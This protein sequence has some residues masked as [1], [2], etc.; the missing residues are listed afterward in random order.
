MTISNF[1]VKNQ[2]LLEGKN[3]KLLQ[4]YDSLVALKYNGDLYLGKDHDYSK[5]TSK[6]VT[7][8]TGLTT[9]ERRQ[10]LKNGTIKELNEKVLSKVRMSL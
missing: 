4:S 1:Y 2:F 8:F 9:K 3:F 7:M 10:G 6:Y 5:T